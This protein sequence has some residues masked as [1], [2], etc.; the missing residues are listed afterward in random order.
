[1]KQDVFVL[2]RLHL[3]GD[4]GEARRL[5]G[6]KATLPRNEQGFSLRL[7]PSRDHELDWDADIAVPRQPA[8]LAL[9][10]AN[11]LELKAARR[12]AWRTPAEHIG[13][14]RAEL[15]EVV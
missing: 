14:L 10:T 9:G 8:A 2:R 1:M 4:L 5:G 3:A 6:L 7:Q 13:D 12:Q 11:H 15:V